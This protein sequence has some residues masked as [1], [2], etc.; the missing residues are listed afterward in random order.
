MKLVA[1][2]AADQLLNIA[3]VDASFVLLD[4]NGDV[5]ISARSLGEINVQVI[6]EKMGGGGHLTAAAASL[7]NISVE[8]AE[9]ELLKHIVEYLEK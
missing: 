8:F 9:K 2:M 6:L 5:G 1:A 4:K 7:E 3:G